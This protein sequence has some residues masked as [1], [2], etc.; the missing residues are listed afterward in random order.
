MPERLAIIF[1]AQLFDK[2]RDE[3][4]ELLSKVIAIGGDMK[5]DELGISDED[6][7]ILIENV[8]VVFHSAATVKFNEKIREAI[9]INV[10]G[11]MKMM[12]LCKK[13]NDLKVSLMNF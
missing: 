8:S 1:K 13:M 5:S 3:N 11:T 9:D 4:P 12:D 10:K 7:Q 2:I 6:Q